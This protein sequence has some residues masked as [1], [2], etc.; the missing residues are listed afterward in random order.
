MV[1]VAGAYFFSGFNKLVFSGPAWVTGPNLRWVLYTASDGRAHPVAAALFIADRAW[2]SHLVAAATI[3]IELGFPA[4]FIKPRLGWLFV[5]GAVGLH[6]AIWATM[7]LDYSA[8]AITAIVVFIPW[9]ALA[10]RL[11]SWRTRTARPVPV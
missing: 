9:P 10:D 7:H 2:L 4:A 3:G 5:P 1:V 8:W 11:R 6:A